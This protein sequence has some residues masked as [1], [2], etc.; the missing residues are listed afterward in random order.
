MNDVSQALAL[1]QDLVAKLTKGIAESRASTTIVG[2]KPLL[3]LL[4]SGYWVFG[5][6]DSEV[7][8]GSTWAINP[9]SLGHGWAAWTNDPDP[10]AKN[11]LVGEVMA[12][13]TEPKPAR[14]ADVDG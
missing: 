4:K 8:E 12:G 10:R 3:R 6:E 2:G 14:P 7:Q 11:Q 13:M 5:V 1:S 9:L